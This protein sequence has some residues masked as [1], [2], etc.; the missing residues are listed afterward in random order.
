MYLS[1]VTKA[2]WCAVATPQISR[3]TCRQALRHLRLGE[4]STTVCGLQGQSGVQALRGVGRGMCG[5]RNNP[6]NVRWLCGAICVVLIFVKA[7]Y[8]V[9][10]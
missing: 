9:F 10:T 3:L 2:C 6:L 4:K 7:L 5:K 8:V 1:A